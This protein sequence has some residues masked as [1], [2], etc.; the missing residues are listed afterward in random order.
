MNATPGAPAWQGAGLP[1]VPPKRNRLASH[2][3]RARAQQPPGVRAQRLAPHLSAAGR[4]HCRRAFPGGFPLPDRPVDVCPSTGR[5]HRR[6][7]AVDHAC[8]C[9]ENT[10]ESCSANTSRQPSCPPRWPR[11]R[12]ERW[13]LPPHR[14]LRRQRRRNAA[15]GP[16]TACCGAVTAV[17]HRPGCSRSTRAPFE[18]FEDETGGGDRLGAPGGPTLRGLPA[19]RHRR[20]SCQ[21]LPC[22]RDRRLSTAPAMASSPLALGCAGAA[23][24]VGRSGSI[25]RWSAGLHMS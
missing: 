12:P 11:C 8:P 20:P 22:R 24:E 13:P 23:G 6:Q 18:V 4:P 14:R 21:W 25:H 1:P 15:S 17:T 19:G 16:T 5:S 9:I 7:A 10:G 3:S 2:Q